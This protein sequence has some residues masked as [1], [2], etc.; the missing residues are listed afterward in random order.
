MQHQRSYRR[1]KSRKKDNQN[2][3]TSGKHRR[4]AKCLSLD[5]ILLTTRGI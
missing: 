1:E 2:V 3:M 5:S 4:D